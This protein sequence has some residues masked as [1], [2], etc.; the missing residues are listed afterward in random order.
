MLTL[1]L[2]ERAPMLDGPTRPLSVLV[3]EDNADAR[4]ITQMMLRL[5]GF[6]AV[7]A[8]DGPAALRAAREHPPDVVLLDIG[9]PGLDGYEVARRLREQAVGKRP[10]LVAVS[11][12][13]KA[14]DKARAAAAGIDLHLTK[15]ADPAVLLHVLHRMQRL[16]DEPQ[17]EV[18]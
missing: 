16:L 18:A 4:Q 2:P 14:E 5:A 11:G 6:F 7:T 17:P 8:A 13:G 12:Y 3:V 1:R 9:L 10:L 15:P